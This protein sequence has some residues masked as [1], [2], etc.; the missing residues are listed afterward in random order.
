ME[1]IT[2]GMPLLRIEL[3]DNT[4]GEDK[5]DSI[6]FSRTLP[7]IGNESLTPVSSRQQINSDN[8]FL[9]QGLE[10]LKEADFNVSKIWNWRDRVYRQACSQ[11]KEFK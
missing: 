8:E 9:K 10:C 4:N 3:P 11:I 5:E 1:S 6:I 7:H 2:L